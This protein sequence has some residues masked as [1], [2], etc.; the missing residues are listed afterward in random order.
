LQFGSSIQGFGIKARMKRPRSEWEHIGNK[1]QFRRFKQMCHVNIHRKLKELMGETAKFRRLQ[2]KTIYAIMTGQSPIVS[3]MAIGEGKSLLFMLPAYYVSGGTTVVI[4][5]LC[6]L[7]EDLERRCREAQIECV[8]WDSQKPHKTASIVLV[9]PESV[10][11]KT[12]N[13]YINRLQSTYQLD[14]IVI[15]ECHVVLDSRLNF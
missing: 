3:I 7:Q 14:R 2:E 12:F 13:T 15:D 8:Q 11:T 10:V 1:V 9:T 6:S 4:I 5:P